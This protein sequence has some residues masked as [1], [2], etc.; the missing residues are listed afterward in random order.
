MSAVNFVPQGTLLVKQNT[1]SSYG[2]LNARVNWHLDA[3]DVD[4]SFFGKNL[5]NKTF[6]DQGYTVEVAG[7]D[8]VLYGPPRTY[9]IEVIKKF[10]Q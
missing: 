3:P 6:F 8:V 4:L 1:Q 10:G 9:G 5:T 7:F 2:L